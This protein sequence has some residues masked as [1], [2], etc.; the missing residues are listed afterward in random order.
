MTAFSAA[1]D[2]LFTDP[3]LSLAAR[4]RAGGQG[5]GLPVRV[6]RRSPDRIGNFGEGR[7]VT[8]SCLIDV[9]LSE[10]PLLEAGDTFQIGDLLYELRGEPV[11][12]S[13]GLTWAAEARRL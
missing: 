11:R 5:E 10:I 4:H 6:I 9:R 7:F 13:E 12:D 1:I 2:L 3:H 8:D